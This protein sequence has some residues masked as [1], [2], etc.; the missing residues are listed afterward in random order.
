MPCFEGHRCISLIL[1]AAVIIL[2]K[3][4]WDIELVH[5]HICFAVVARLLALYSLLPLNSRSRRCIRRKLTR[6]IQPKKLNCNKQRL[7]KTRLTIRIMNIIFKFIFF[8]NSKKY[9]PRDLWTSSSKLRCWWKGDK[10][11]A[12]RVRWRRHCRVMAIQPISWRPCLL[13]AKYEVLIWWD[14]NYDSI[15]TLCHKIYSCM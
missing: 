2:S 13:I 15:F 3:D 4:T 10:E 5:W 14:A 8:M 9:L 1:S 6:I 7:A 12:W 11:K